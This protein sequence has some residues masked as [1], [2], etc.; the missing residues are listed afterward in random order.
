MTDDYLYPETV[1]YAHVDDTGQVL[2]VGHVSGVVWAAIGGG[3]TLR[4]TQEQFA[5]LS[6]AE[7]HYLFVDGVLSA[8]PSPPP[9]L[10]DVI[11]AV[12]ARR[13][14][15][16]AHTD[17]TQMADH[18]MSAEQRAAWNTYRQALRDVPQQPGFPEAVTWP[19]Q[20]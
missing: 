11:K 17:W 19:E 20:P 6:R 18:P 12:R 7:S 4:L 5:T 14:Q 1:H 16:I 8:I 10:E 3:H 13:L 9:P 2:A 15:L